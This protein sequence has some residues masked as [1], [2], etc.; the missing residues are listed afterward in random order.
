MNPEAQLISSL[1]QFIRS[2]RA[3]GLSYYYGRVKKIKTATH[4]C[5]VDLED[6]GLEVE[7]NLRVGQQALESYFVTYPKL[8]SQVLFL[9]EGQNFGRAYLIQCSEVDRIELRGSA[10]GGLIKIEALTAKVN[11][12]IDKLNSNI[13]QV[14]SDLSKLSN[15]FKAHTHLSTAPG[16]P[17]G[18]ISASTPPTVVAPPATLTDAEALSKDD[19]ENT[20]I[21]HGGASDAEQTNPQNS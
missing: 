20:T 13:S 12:A 21:L 19:Y 3:D 16:S 1:Q 18:L 8:G 2:G 7:V 17:T 15:Q 6:E 11:A 10:F 9:S 5:L 4:T 14:R